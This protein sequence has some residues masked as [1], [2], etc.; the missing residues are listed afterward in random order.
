MAARSHPPL[1]R[2]V[3]RAALTGAV[4][5][6]PLTAAMFATVLWPPPAG[7]LLEAFPVLFVA[8]GV[9]T[10]GVV[11]LEEACRRYRW[12]RFAAPAAVL[13]LLA[14]A[15]AALLWSISVQQTGLGPRT[16]ANFERS[17]AEVA[18][19]RASL[20]A[21][22]GVGLTA[23]LGVLVARG[24]YAADPTTQ[25]ALKL[26]AAA[27]AAT[28]LVALGVVA[29]VDERALTRHPAAI[30]ACLLLLPFVTVGGAALGERLE[31]GLARRWSRGDR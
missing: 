19:G 23:A 21:V 24:V 2:V 20:Q 9:L 1:H 15:L 10:G 8:L 7:A 16:V 18:S 5:G 13:G 29:L 14:A 31:R 3:A 25:P 17:V 12:L 11:L 6:L 22:W 26:Q 4:T 30:A 28:T 27:A